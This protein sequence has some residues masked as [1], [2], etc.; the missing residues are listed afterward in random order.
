VSKY[1]N[2][3]YLIF[4]PSSGTASLYQWNS[5]PIGVSTNSWNPNY[6]NL[7][8]G[9]AVKDLRG[10]CPI[11]WV[12]GNDSDWNILIQT[13]DS[14]ANPNAFL[15]SNLAGS[16]LKSINGWNSPNFANNQSG[17]S[18]YPAHYRYGTGDYHGVN[19]SYSGFWTS[20]SASPITNLYIRSFGNSNGDILREGQNTSWGF[21]IR[22]LKKE[23]PVVITDSVT[24][25]KS[26]SA[27]LNGQLTNDW[28]DVHTVKGFCYSTSPNPTTSN[29]T[30]L[31][32]SGGVGSYFD[33]IYGLNPATNYYVRSY[34]INNLGISYGSEISFRTSQLIVGD[35]YG[36][37]YVVGFDSMTQSG[38]ICAP[39]DIGRFP[40]GC[41]GTSISGT[42]QSVG[43][44][45]SNTN[46]ILAGC[47]TRPIS[48]SI[49][50]DTILNGFSDWF[51][52]SAQE[53]LLAY[54]RL[55]PL[56][57]GNLGS[58][59]ITSTQVNTN[60]AN[61]VNTSSGVF[62]RIGQSWKSDN[63]LAR[64]F[65]YFN[66]SASYFGCGTSVVSDVDGNSYNTV[67]IG[68]Q[69]WTK[70]NL[71]VS[72]Y[73]NGDSVLTGLSNTAWQ[74]TTAGAYAIYNNDPV[75]DGLYGKLYNHYA[76]MDSRGLCPTGWHVPT[77]GEW[78][79]LE[80][81]LGGSSVAGEAIKS[82]SVQPTSGGWLN[83]NNGATNSSGF[84][85]EPGGTRI[86]FGSVFAYLNA[87]G[88]W[89]SSSL[90]GSDAW[91][92]ELS[93]GNSVIGRYIY[94]S[95]SGLSVRCLRD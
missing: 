84:T 50:A 80:T 27:R 82:T 31:F 32:G 59:N 78:T 15:Q 22:C 1:R 48:A 60:L 36:G 52:P 63:S 85:A 58:N 66:L 72:K 47:T 95:S 87:H 29:D 17:F 5:S 2:G 33:S 81:F 61:D 25:I 34:A 91:G 24:H 68:T 88:Y 76:V 14:N 79:I 62:G 28:G 11:G 70:S 71:K 64:P 23:L 86:N 18:A 67:Q 51:L 30:V 54:I 77:D 53:L 92:R 42:S 13:L 73:R 19:G 75:N 21:S 10:L 94:P 3:D 49:C 56:N 38:I 37:G 93:Y 45:L 69:C 9:Y 89:W 4:Y 44:G 12:V 74:N 35:S 83:P 57:I 90:S 39:S 65:R 41:M 55:K 7:Y 26:T 40:W 20:T 43:S 6:G 46:L 8:N 16:K